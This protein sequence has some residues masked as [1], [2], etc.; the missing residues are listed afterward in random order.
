MKVI[1][2]DK[3][4]AVFFKSVW[5]FKHVMWK[6]RLQEQYSSFSWQIKTVQLPTYWHYFCLNNAFNNLSAGIFN[7]QFILDQLCC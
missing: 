6:S 4:L 5:I 7:I 3:G 1:S 2:V